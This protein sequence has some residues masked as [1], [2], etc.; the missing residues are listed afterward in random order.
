VELADADARSDRL[1]HRPFLGTGQS[2]SAL[3]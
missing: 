1:H 2:L 3:V